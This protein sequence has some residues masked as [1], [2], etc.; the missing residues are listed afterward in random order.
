MNVFFE[1]TPPCCFA[2]LLSLV[3]HMHHKHIV[4]MYELEQKCTHLRPFPSSKKKYFDFISFNSNF[5]LSPL[6]MILSQRTTWFKAYGKS[7]HKITKII[8]SEV[9]I[10]IQQA[11]HAD[12]VLIYNFSF[13]INLINK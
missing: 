8:Q 6:K 9:T 7:S 5:G 13:S 12:G 2:A 1:S 4:T 3:A 10:L 11:K